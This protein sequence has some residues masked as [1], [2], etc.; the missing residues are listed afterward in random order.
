MPQFA[1]G[2]IQSGK[3]FQMESEW[4][5]GRGLPLDSGIAKTEVRK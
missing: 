5:G 3:E 2:R 1:V 4:G